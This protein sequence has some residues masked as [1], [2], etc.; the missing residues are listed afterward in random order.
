MSYGGVGLG[1]IQRATSFAP[2]SAGPAAYNVNL[3]GG[4]VGPDAYKY[5]L[6][7]TVGPDAYK[8]DDS[9]YHL[10]Q[11]DDAGHEVVA[12]EGG[13]PKWVWIAGGVGAL[14]LVGLA[15]FLSKRPMRRNYRRGVVLRSGQSE[16][17][18]TRY[19]VVSPYRAKKIAGS[20]KRLRRR[21]IRRSKAYV[22]RLREGHR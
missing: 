20:R 13:V 18:G 12:D 5:N 9:G 3:P 10:D 21:R 2:R 17:G 4:T 14:A 15:V 1:L 16:Y 6:P 7:G 19:R 22:K 8:V 11:K